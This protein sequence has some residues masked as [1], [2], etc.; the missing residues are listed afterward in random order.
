MRQRLYDH[1][2]VPLSSAS[3]G[4]SRSH[5]RITRASKTVSRGQDNSMEQGGSTERD[6]GME[7]G[8]LKLER[9]DSMERGK[10]GSSSRGFRPGRN[11][12]STKVGRCVYVSAWGGLTAV[13]SGFGL[14]SHHQQARGALPVVAGC[15]HSRCWRARRTLLAVVDLSQPVRRAL[16]S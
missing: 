5:R 8:E 2:K 1:S 13:V 3:V 6:D 14:R 16:L 11:N 9:D 4:S 12:A 15:G 7:Q 10:A